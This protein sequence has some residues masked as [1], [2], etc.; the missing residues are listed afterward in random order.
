MNDKPIQVGPLLVKRVPSSAVRYRA[1]REQYWHGY[2]VPGTA[3][4]Q[5]INEIG[6]LIEVTSLQ[7][8][9]A[10]RDAYR[11]EIDPFAEVEF[12]Y[13]AVINADV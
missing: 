2:I 4:K 5:S 1:I 7:Q 6:K 3:S 10:E 9:N 8:L 12:A 11:A 13:Y